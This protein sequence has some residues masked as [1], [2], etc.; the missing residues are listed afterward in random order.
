M[1]EPT[2][3]YPVRTRILHWLTAILIFTALFV[4]FVMV[5]SI[6]SYRVARRACT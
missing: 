4:G 1:T 2:A 6:G 5:N 3:R